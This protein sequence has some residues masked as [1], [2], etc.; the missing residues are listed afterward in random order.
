MTPPIRSV[1]GNSSEK[2]AETCSLC[3]APLDPIRV[4]TACGHHASLTATQRIVQLVD[5]GTFQEYDRHMWS[6]NPIH[7][8]AGATSYEKQLAQAQAATGLRDAVVTGRA[9]LM[10][11]AVVLVVFDFRFLG[12]SMG[13]VVGEKIARA[14]DAARRERVPVIAVPTSVGYGVAAGGA[15][16]LN[17]ALAS[18]APGV[19]TVNID[20]GFGAALAATLIN[21]VGIERDGR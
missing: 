5:R 6:G 19:V 17:S 12:G 13:S 8:S 18:C 20:N 9:R 4:C 11:N 3:A 1:P 7:F 2:K 14:F 21:R 10:G 16:A 15:T